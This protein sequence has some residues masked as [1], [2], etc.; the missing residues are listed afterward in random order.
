[1]RPYAGRS[2]D[3][4]WCPRESTA[5]STFRPIRPP[6]SGTLCD[7]STGAHWSEELGHMRLVW[8]A[9]VGLPNESRRRSFDLR[10]HHECGNPKG[11]VKRGPYRVKQASRVYCR[12]MDQF[13][14][15]RGRHPFRRSCIRGQD[16]TGPVFTNVDSPAGM[17]RRVLGRA[18]TTSATYENGIDSACVVEGDPDSRSEDWRIRLVID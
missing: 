10:S 6:G 7:V 3:T 15:A 14:Q 13:E 12:Y 5:K 8:C 9:G 1:M 4:I 2:A 18:A 11:G 17:R 16:H